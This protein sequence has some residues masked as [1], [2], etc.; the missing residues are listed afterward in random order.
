MNLLDVATPHALGEFGIAFS[1]IG[2]PCE[3]LTVQCRTCGWLALHRGSFQDG[4]DVL[5][6]RLREHR[7]QAHPVA[8]A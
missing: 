5:L 6:K 2:A 4:A 8:R 3:S 7:A 1:P